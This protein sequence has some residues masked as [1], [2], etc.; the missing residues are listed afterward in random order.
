MKH[1]AQKQQ[2]KHT[3]NLNELANENQ[4]KVTH[5]KHTAQKQKGTHYEKNMKHTQQQVRPTT[6]GTQLHA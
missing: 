2:A 3:T 1:T 6:H 4:Q 5:V